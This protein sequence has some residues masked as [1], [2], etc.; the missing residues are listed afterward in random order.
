M[1]RRQPRSTLFSYTTLF[2][3]TFLTQSN[4]KHMVVLLG[5][6]Q[7]KYRQAGLAKYNVRC[8]GVNRVIE[9]FNAVRV[10]DFQKVSGLRNASVGIATVTQKSFESQ[11]NITRALFGT[12]SLFAM[13]APLFK[14]AVATRTGEEGPP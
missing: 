2:R 14:D 8:S 13:T 4:I 11:Y 5:L 1:I 7:V 10:C 9:V 3:S 6:L 12:R